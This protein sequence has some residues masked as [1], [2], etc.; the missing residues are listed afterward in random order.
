MEGGAIS[1]VTYGET[2]AMNASNRLILSA[3]EVA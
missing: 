3:S 1:R 2:G